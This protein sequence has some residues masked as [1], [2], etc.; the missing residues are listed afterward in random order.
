MKDKSDLEA[1]PR[2]AIKDTTFA[3]TKVFKPLTF[4]YYLAITKTTYLPK[5][6]PSDKGAMTNIHR[7]FFQSSKFFTGSKFGF[8]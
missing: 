7:L 6:H 5:G 2:R 8:L 3:R 1:S 4:E